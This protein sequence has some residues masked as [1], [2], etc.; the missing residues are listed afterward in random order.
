MFTTK[1]T[2][3]NKSVNWN[4]LKLEL[5]EDVCNTKNKHI[6]ISIGFLA[7]I[8]RKKYDSE[9]DVVHVLSQYIY[10]YSKYKGDLI[11]LLF[12]RAINERWWIT[13]LCVQ[14]ELLKEVIG[15]EYNRL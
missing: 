10:Q 2:G 4:I 8:V 15:S 6:K 11:A 14:K 9:D 1:S 13:D 7:D 5:L 12:L 3:N